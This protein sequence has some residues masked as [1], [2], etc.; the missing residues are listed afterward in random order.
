MIFC[1]QNAVSFF[2]DA[3]H[4]KD[5]FLAFKPCQPLRRIMQTNYAR[6]SRTED[7]VPPM[8]RG[9]SAWH[10]DDHALSDEDF[11]APCPF[12]AEHCPW[13]CCCCCALSRSHRQQCALTLLYAKGYLIIYLLIIAMTLTLL[14]YD[15][16]NG[17]IIHDLKSEPFWIVMVDICCV[18]LMVI[19]VLVQVCQKYPRIRAFYFLHFDK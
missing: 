6:L 16:A 4:L 9:A 15:L 2:I 12:I 10:A 11:E 13:P 1:T 18:S 3:A 19:D 7:D 5:F 17:H 8:P 14:I